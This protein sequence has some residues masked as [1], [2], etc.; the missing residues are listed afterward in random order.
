MI[1]DLL[2]KYIFSWIKN[3][4]L[5]HLYSEKISVDIIL[6]NHNKMAIGLLYN[7]MKMVSPTVFIKG[8][9]IY[10]QK[11]IDMGKAK[12]I[13]ISDEPELVKRLFLNVKEGRQIPEMYLE[14]MARVYYK[15]DLE[16]DDLLTTEDKSQISSAKDDLYSIKANDYNQRSKDHEV[17]SI[18]IPEKIELQLSK[19]LYSLVKDQFIKVNI[20]GLQIFKIKTEENLNFDNEEYCIKINGTSVKHGKISY[21][22]IEPF[23]QLCIFLKNCLTFYSKELLGRDDILHIINQVKE[24]HPALVYDIMNNFSLSEIRN[25]LCGLLQEQV[26]IQNITTIF[27]SIAD[28]SDKDYDTDTIIE[29]VRKSIGR[30]ICIPYLHEN[31]ILKAIGL[32]YELEIMIESNIIL[33]AGGKT[34]NPD[35]N[36]KLLIIVNEALE[37]VKAQNIKPVFL[38]NIVNRKF[39]YETLKNVDPNIAVLSFLEIPQD[40]I[41]E[42]LFV[43]NLREPS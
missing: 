17:L 36:E 11:I 33:I 15:K 32:S 16:K 29:Y 12:G 9:S 24:K 27:E 20:L 42:Y 26:S 18:N 3:K 28:F 39:L 35:F 22:S 2:D 5:Q 25:I 19:N 23:Q 21:I 37:E 4:K 13:F 43:M 7:D 41:L 1:N 6:T 34:I 8:R 31:K 30:E 40:C 38:C 14:A 10:A